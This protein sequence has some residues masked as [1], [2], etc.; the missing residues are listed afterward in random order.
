MSNLLDLRRHRFDA[1]HALLLGGIR[2]KSP[3]IYTENNRLRRD[4]GLPEAPGRPSPLSL[5]EPMVGL[6]R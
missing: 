2:M 1:L 5:A 3:D 6:R 4:V